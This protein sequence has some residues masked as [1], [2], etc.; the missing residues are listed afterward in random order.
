MIILSN[1]PEENRLDL[2]M[3]SVIFLF[4]NKKF[5][6]VESRE[7]QYKKPNI[8]LKIA[9]KIDSEINIKIG[10]NLG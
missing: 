5:V 3:L 10:P 2:S 9:L 8:N 1:Q 6:K 4:L 7:I